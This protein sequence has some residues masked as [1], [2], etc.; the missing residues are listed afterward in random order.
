M[1]IHKRIRFVGAVIALS[2][3]TGSALASSPSDFQ[4]LLVDPKAFD[5]K[6]VT[7]VGIADVYG[8]GFFLYERA[9]RDGKPD[10]SRSVFVVDKPNRTLPSELDKHW[11]KVTGQVDARAGGPYGTEPCE[12]KLDHFDALPIPPLKERRTFGIFRNDTSSPVIFKI[13]GPDGYSTSKLG[14]SAK[15]IEGIDDKNTV[16]ASTPAGTLI[17]KSSISSRSVGKYFDPINRT[18]YYRITN[19]KIEL[20]SPTEGKAWLKGHNAIP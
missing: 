4:K 18:Y 8:Y 7:L 11:V 3:I 19:G 1:S 14:P 10:F 13:S 9:L 15:T 17:A 16:V 20:V 2:L 5:A 12:I 6:R